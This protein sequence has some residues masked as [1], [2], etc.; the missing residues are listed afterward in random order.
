[1]TDQ[2]QAKLTAQ[3]VTESLTG[4]DEIAI[5]D[6]FGRTLEE[7][8]DEEGHRQIMLMRALGAVVVAR[9]KNLEAGSFPKA[10]KDAY[11]EVMGMRQSQVTGLFAEEPDDVMP[12]EPDSESGKD[13]SVPMSEPTASLHSA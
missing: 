12:D 6:A 9:S 8:A 13:D 1:M 10:F 2:E 11:R 4:W 5:E 7:M 3:E